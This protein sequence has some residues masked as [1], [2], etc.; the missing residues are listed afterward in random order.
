M[1]TRIRLEPSA[2]D[3]SRCLQDGHWCASTVEGGIL[4]PYTSPRGH[5]YL[6]SGKGY[7]PGQ[8]LTRGTRECLAIPNQRVC[9]H[10][11]AG[12]ASPY[13]WDSGQSSWSCKLFGALPFP[14]WPP[15]PAPRCSS[16]S[17][18]RHNCPRA[19]ATR[20]QPGLVHLLVQTHGLGPLS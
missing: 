17:I 14:R 13:I 6:W 16:S 9:H 7:Q 10:L 19:T 3:A 18:L 20:G 4:I 5:V 2:R 1:R 12:A 15:R 11:R 8:P